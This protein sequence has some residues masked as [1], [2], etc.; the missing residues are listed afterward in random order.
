MI[1]R[2]LYFGNP[3]YLSMKDRQLVVQKEVTSPGETLSRTRTDISTIPIEDIGVVMLDNPQITLT[4]PLLNALL[5]NNTAVI[6]CNER[7]MPSGMLL[8]LEGNTLQAERYSNQI[9]ASVPLKKQLW[10][11]IIQAKIANQAAV[12]QEKGVDIE[13]MRYFQRNVRSGDPDNYEGRAAAYY[14][15]NLFDGV[16]EGEFTRGRFEDDPNNLLNYG[17]AVLRAVIA[18]SLVGSGLLPTLG[19]HHRNKYNAFCL[20]DDI[21]EPYR[22][23]VDRLVLS[24]LNDFDDVST[25]TTELKA[26]LLVIPALDVVIDG[27]SS[28]LMVA[29]QRTTA[30]LND[31]FEGASRKVL[32]PVIL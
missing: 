17:Y 26:R 9:N 31:C 22:P 10:Q 2:T 16:V 8:P 3:A 30:S 1:K 4:H 24:I 25:L 5:A 28:P 18:R 6:T 7:H 32:H 11:Q 29:S 19:I 23:Y 20:A 21:M 12:L 14:W 13:P 27:K 15:K